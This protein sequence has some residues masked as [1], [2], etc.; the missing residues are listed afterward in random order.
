MNNINTR[1][2]LV[3]NLFNKINLEYPVQQLVTKKIL[4]KILENCDLKDKIKIKNIYNT[5]IYK[6]KNSEEIKLN[7]KKLDDLLNK[8]IQKETVDLGVKDVDIKPK[9]NNLDKIKNINL[10]IDSIQIDKEE[11][12]NIFDFCVYFDK[13][14]NKNGYIK[15]QLNMIK[16]VKLKNIVI[17]DAFENI[18][19]IMLEI[20]ELGSDFIS[21][22]T[23][24]K[25][26]FC[27]L[28]N[29]D[30]LNG[31]RYY[32]INKKIEFDVPKTFNKLSIKFNDHLGNKIVNESNDIFFN[33]NFELEKISINFFNNYSEIQI[34]D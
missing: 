12:K 33:L 16:S 26:A 21:N 11:H 13:E 34:K 5:L 27:M 19:Y 23:K 17:K 3:D 6:I 32:K 20:E 28:Y 29:Y 24:I 31:Y 1:N 10:V 8:S 4:Y 9:V 18:P 22:N 15:E 14:E 30:L 7:N 2:L 25:N